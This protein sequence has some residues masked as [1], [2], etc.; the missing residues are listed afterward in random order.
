[1]S[2]IVFEGCDLSGKSETA[3][4]FAENLRTQGKKCLLTREPGG[5]EQGEA[6]RELLARS[7]DWGETA[8]ALLFYAARAEHIKTLRQ[9]RNEGFWVVS[10]R[11][12]LSTSVY[13]Q[14]VGST[15]LEALRASIVGD[16][17]PDLWLILD[18]PFEQ[19]A[20]R[21]LALF[22]DN[23][24]NELQ[25]YEKHNRNGWE[26]IRNEYLRLAKSMPNAVVVDASPPLEQVTAEA[27]KI[28][29]QRL[30]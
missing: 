29:E 11:F 5:T 12:Y 2:F 30:A 25:L 19:A 9:K 22:G 16:F 1:M 18:L 14:K 27:I 6:M 13:Q 10:D 24:P 8:K 4:L 7:A 21:R 20:K 3:R 15:L 23:R 17:E 26:K 28:A